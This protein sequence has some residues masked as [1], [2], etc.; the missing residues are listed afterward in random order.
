MN[1]EKQIIGIIREQL[2]ISSP[3]KG[4]SRLYDIGVDSL[5]F[6]EF[7]IKIENV[8]MIEFEDEYLNYHLF[9]TIKQVSDYVEARIKLTA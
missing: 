9:E 1:P 4:D 5:K 6:I 7:V 2:E 8:F 3:L